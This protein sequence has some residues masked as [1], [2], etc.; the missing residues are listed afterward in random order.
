[1]LSAISSK[2][3]ISDGMGSISAY[4]MGSLHVMEGTMNA[5]RYI[6]V[7]DNI[8]SPPDDVYFREG[9][10]YFSRTMQNHILQ[11]LQQHGFVVEESGCIIKFGASLNENYIKDD[12][13]L[14]SSWKTISGKNGTTF[15][16]QNSRNS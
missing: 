8:C 9:L 16:H 14:F 7:L 3:S 2:A 15:Q 12:H 6:K 5:E 11:L 13:K 1:M 4:G 10:V